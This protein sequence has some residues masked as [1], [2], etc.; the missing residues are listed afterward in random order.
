MFD[1]CH[2]TK[3]KERKEKG[4][5]ERREGRREGRRKGSQFCSV[6]LLK[7]SSIPSSAGGEQAVFCG[8]RSEAGGETGGTSR[9]S[10]MLQSPSGDQPTPWRK[11]AGQVVPMTSGE[12]VMGSGGRHR[13]E[14]INSCP[15]G[16]NGSQLPFLRKR[17]QGLEGG[18]RV[19]HDRSG[20]FLKEKGSPQLPS[21]WYLEKHRPLK[22]VCGLADG[23]GLMPTCHHRGKASPTSLPTLSPCMTPIF[24]RLLRGPQPD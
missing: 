24:L 14:G 23:P 19:L 21:W 3:L 1:I 17:W 16:C 20:G 15:G 13:Q 7:P 12:R 22:A 11:P 5:Q 6:S 2:D 9:L 4:R 10:P 18:G 8:W